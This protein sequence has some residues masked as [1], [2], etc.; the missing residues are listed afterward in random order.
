MFT[1]V[2]VPDAG[3]VGVR[4]REGAAVAPDQEDARR[5]RHERERVLVDVDDVAA[6]P[7]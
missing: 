6:G 2:G 4:G 1:N 5:A 3:D 7:L